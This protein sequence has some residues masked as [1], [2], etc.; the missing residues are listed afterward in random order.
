MKHLTKITA[1]AFATCFAFM[2]ESFAQARPIPEVPCPAGGEMVPGY[3]FQRQLA[4]SF[5]QL[6]SRTQSTGLRV[7][8]CP[9]NRFPRYRSFTEAEG[10]ILDRLVKTSAYREATE[11]MHPWERVLWIEERFN[12]ITPKKRALVLSRDLDGLD[13]DAAKDVYRVILPNL[14]HAI[15]NDKGWVF[16][17]LGNRAPVGYED[18]ARSEV[19]AQ[20]AYMQHQIGQEG[21]ARAWLERARRTLGSKPPFGNDSGWRDAD[22]RIRLTD[23]CLDSPTKYREALCS[24][25]GVQSFSLRVQQCLQPFPDVPI[26]LKLPSK[27]PATL[28]NSAQNDACKWIKGF[29]QNPKKLVVQINF[30]RA[31]WPAFRDLFDLSYRVESPGNCDLRQTLG[32]LCYQSAPSERWYEAVRLFPGLSARW[33]HTV[34]YRNSLLRLA[35]ELASCLEEKTQISCKSFENPQSVMKK[36]RAIDG[37]VAVV[38]NARIEQRHSKLWSKAICDAFVSFFSE[39]R[40]TL[41]LY[42]SPPDAEQSD[43]P[44]MAIATVRR[45]LVDALARCDFINELELKLSNGKP[46]RCGLDAPT[47]AQLSTLRQST[48]DFE[49]VY[50]AALQ[51]LIRGRAESIG[52]NLARHSLRGSYRDKSRETLEAE[53]KQLIASYPDAAAWLAEAERATIDSATQLR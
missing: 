42:P 5:L 17:G 10:K 4:L 47:P 44:E 25:T 31:E 23:V 50:S 48:H 38:E 51:K 1:L 11:A 26:T 27:P 33:K 41:D 6:D 22:M 37:F 40:I 7:F 30:L 13:R 16:K 34:E 2:A 32:L 21:T 19:M 52:G 3:T 14:I 45:K 8:E 39:C 18:K 28:K 36:G 46:Q 49:A 29:S 15:E 35:R 43:F 24:T 12:T 9:G 20:I 53:K